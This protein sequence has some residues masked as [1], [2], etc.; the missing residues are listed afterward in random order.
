[1]SNS[2][3]LMAYSPRMTALTIA[4]RGAEFKVL[5]PFTL[6]V[7]SAPDFDRESPLCF[8]PYGSMMMTT[9]QTGG[10]FFWKLDQVRVRLA[11]IGLDWEHMR[12]FP[13]LQIPLVKKVELRT[14]ATN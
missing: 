5:N 13:V 7:L 14:Q 10:L 6:E 11:M 2:S 12:P 1:M 3:G 8:D 4:Y 9:G